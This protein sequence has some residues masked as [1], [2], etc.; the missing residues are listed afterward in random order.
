MSQ[1]EATYERPMSAW[2]SPW[3]IGWVLLVTVVLGVNLV[4]I[5]LAV[6][7]SPGLV[8]DDYYDRGQNYERTLVSRLARE[9]GWSMRADIPKGLKAGETS[10]VRFFVVDKAGQPITPDQVTFYAYRPADSEQD[11]SLP[12]E[13][14]GEGRYAAKL[15]FPLMGV[16]D[17][18]IAA[19]TGEDEY[20]LGQRISILRP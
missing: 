17:T 15:Q 2:R 6:V 8:V 12:M 3:V 19:S 9:P 7:T 14:E 11:F 16:W 20:S 4:M 13:S 5:Y 1:S 10:V 18:M